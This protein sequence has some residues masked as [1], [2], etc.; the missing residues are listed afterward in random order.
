M[1]GRPNRRNK[2]TFSNSSGLKSVFEKLRFR[3]GSVWTVSL[4]AEI[5]HAF[6]NSSGVSADA[7]WEIN[8]RTFLWYRMRCFFRKLHSITFPFNHKVMDVATKVN[9]LTALHK[10]NIVYSRGNTMRL[11]NIYFTKLLAPLIDC[12]KSKL[13]LVRLPRNCPKSDN[14]I[15]T[16]VPFPGLS[17]CRAWG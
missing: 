16:I 13:C 6:S 11:F 12:L 3:D 1:D 14:F 15:R 2:A 4:T 5:K 8:Y 10:M 17:S 7:A 9:T